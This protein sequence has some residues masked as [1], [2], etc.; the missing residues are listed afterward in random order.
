[1]SQGRQSG[2][3][4]YAVSAL[5]VMLSV[6]KVFAV[7]GDLQSRIGEL[8]IRKDFRGEYDLVEPLARGGNAEAQFYFATLFARGEGV[9]QNEDVALDWAQ[10]SAEQGYIE[11]E[12]YLGTLLL[13]RAVSSGDSADIAVGWI[14]KAADH[15]LVAAMG[16]LWLIYDMG[17]GVMRDADQAAY[18]HERWIKTPD[19]SSEWILKRILEHD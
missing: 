6:I 11:A 13:R 16:S 14:R 8:R 12:Y 19:P 5:L 1:M 7:E 4:R 18:W 3:G 10:K 17:Y 2:I 15:G 9:D